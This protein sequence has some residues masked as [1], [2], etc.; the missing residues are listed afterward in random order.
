LSSI[1]E[2]H[3]YRMILFLKASGLSMTGSI[4]SLGEALLR[5]CGFGDNGV[6]GQE[7]LS[8]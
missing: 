5:P 3:Q 1:S 6:T 7:P 2:A 8:R 4:A